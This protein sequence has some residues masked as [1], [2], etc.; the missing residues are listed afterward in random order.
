MAEK[1]VGN[2]NLAF[3]RIYTIADLWK[4]KKEKRREEK[5]KKITRKDLEILTDKREERRF[6]KKLC[7]KNVKRPRNL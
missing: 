4:K 1:F 6:A 2:I 7:G 5:R 3:G